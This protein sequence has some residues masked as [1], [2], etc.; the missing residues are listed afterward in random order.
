MKKTLKLV[1]LV[2]TII[3]SVA[4]VTHVA[5]AYVGIA[6]DP[7]TSAPA[8]IAFLLIIP[9]AIAICIVATVWMIL[10]KKEKKEA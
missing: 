5:I 1:F 9:Y 2:V 3:L 10:S 7:Y 6:N 4:M 8:D